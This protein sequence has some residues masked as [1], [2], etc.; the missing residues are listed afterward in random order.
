MVKDPIHPGALLLLDSL[1]GRPVKALPDERARRPA[2]LVFSG[3]RNP[4]IRRQ[5]T[6]TGPTK[7]MVD[8]PELVFDIPLRC[9]DYR[10]RR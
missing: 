3:H 2:Q 10:R 8:D 7:K 9:F 4:Q 5:T 1:A 6:K